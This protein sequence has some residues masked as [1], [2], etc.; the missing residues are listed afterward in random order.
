MAEDALQKISV[1]RTA[2]ESFLTD[3]GYNELLDRALT[4]KQKTLREKIIVFLEN[5]FVFFSPQRQVLR[6][7]WNKDIRKEVSLFIAHATAVVKAIRDKNADQILFLM[8]K[9][10]Y[11]SFSERLPTVYKYVKEVEPKK[12]GIIDEDV[13]RIVRHVVEYQRDDTPYQVYTILKKFRDDLPDPP[14]SWLEGMEPQIAGTWRSIMECLR[15]LIEIIDHFLDQDRFFRTF[16]VK[17]LKSR[18]VRFFPIDEWRRLADFFFSH[19]M[20]FLKTEDPESLN[21]FGKIAEFSRLL[22]RWQEDAGS[23]EKKQQSEAVVVPEDQDDWTAWIQARMG[24][25]RQRNARVVPP[26][27]QQKRTAAPRAQRVRQPPPVIPQAQAQPQALPREARDELRERILQR[28]GEIQDD[29]QNRVSRVRGVNDPHLRRKQANIRR[30]LSGLSRIGRDILERALR[31]EAEVILLLDVKNIMR[32]LFPQ[33]GPGQDRERVE[34]GHPSLLR[35]AVERFLPSPSD[36]LT[37]LDHDRC[38]AVWIDQG[39]LVEDPVVWL[40]EASAYLRISCAD[41]NGADCYKTTDRKNPMDD[42][43]LLLLNDL[44]LRANAETER[45]LN[46]RAAGLLRDIRTLEEAVRDRYEEGAGVDTLLRITGEIRALKRSIRRLKNPI[47][48]PVIVSG[49]RYRDFIR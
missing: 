12:P 14:D 43:V 16:R 29:V 42:Y 22:R 35:M 27:Q 7:K 26:R 45:V 9:H 13:G 18:G 15:V 25:L 37:L 19:G 30:V 3:P 40:D 10:F 49:D 47:P 32:T 1:L 5:D 44:F 11:N 28:I 21:D 24:N 4:G 8:N 31:R 17:I 36:V 39:D 20:H 34:H 2:L 48:E 6:K 38:Y 46:E 41:E 23:Q 33:S